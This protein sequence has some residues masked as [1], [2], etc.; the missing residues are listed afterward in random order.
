[1]EREDKT[2]TAGHRVVIADDHAPTRMGVRRTLELQGFQVPAEAS[3]AAG[4]IA[5]AIREQPDVCLLDI[6]MPGSGITASAEISS[7]LPQ[8]AVVMLTVSADHLSLL[9]SLEAGARGYV[10][11]GTDPD[12]LRRAL[13]RVLDGEFALP[14]SLVARALTEVRSRPGP[15]RFLGLKGQ[16]PEP[17][18]GGW[19]ILELLG[20]GLT[21]AEVAARLSIE[22]DQVRMQVA[23]L[24]LAA[25]SRA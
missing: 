8:T 4:A 11:K 5:A 2:A 16:A 23:A 25:G 17:I 24:P 19:E 3:D 9:A 14:P 18:T 1:L 7:R 20:Q 6:D 21:T 10:V 12:T 15:R 13:W 22:R